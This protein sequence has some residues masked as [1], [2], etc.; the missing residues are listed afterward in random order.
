MLKKE[1]L[2]SGDWLVD[3]YFLRYLHILKYDGWKI[4]IKRRLKDAGDPPEKREVLHGM[5]ILE[6]KVIYLNPALRRHPTKD[7]LGET[8]LHELAHILYES[9][10]DARI[11]RHR[12]IYQLEKLWRRFSGLQKDMILSFIPRKYLPN[13]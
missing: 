11:L 1:K 2:S 6:K 10:E 13:L 5:V 3:W 4:R 9:A 12:N 8:L 7:A